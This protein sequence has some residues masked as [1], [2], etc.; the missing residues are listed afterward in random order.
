MSAW[1]FE[2]GHTAA[3]FRARHMMVTW[4]RGHIKPVHGKVHLD[5]D[6]PRAS[7]FEATMNVGDLWTGVPERDTHLRSA[8]FFDVERHPLI[9]F[10]S[11]RVDQIGQ[12]DYT[13]GGDLTVRGV[14]RPGTLDVRYMGRWQTPYWED[15][16]DKGTMTR[17][18][19]TASTRVNRHDFGV[20]WQDRLPGG[21]IVVSDEVWITL[22]V[23][24]ILEQ[25]LTA[26]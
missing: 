2:P 26:A 18:G 5:F 6:R 14:T 19:F 17:A 23:E 15:G 10:T 21:G 1:V 4:V 12:D 8:D 9:T 25:D 20:S 22:D 24:A 7:S 3:Q 13:A 11:T 16:V